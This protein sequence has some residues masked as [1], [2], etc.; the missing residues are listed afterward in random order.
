MKKKNLLMSNYSMNT[1][2]W[3]QMD[4]ISLLNESWFAPCLSFAFLYASLSFF[5]GHQ[6][7][8]PSGGATRWWPIPN[9]FGE[10]KITDEAC[11]IFTSH[12]GVVWFF[13]GVVTAIPC[14]PGQN[15]PVHWEVRCWSGHRE[16]NV[17]I[18]QYLCFQAWHEVIIFLFL[19][20]SFHILILIKYYEK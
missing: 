5:S 4:N 7:A 13:L 17:Q 14:W 11:E 1:F 19:F 16:R 20:S 10:E 3:I 2:R 9:L 6:R 15:K 8:K 12:S 18:G